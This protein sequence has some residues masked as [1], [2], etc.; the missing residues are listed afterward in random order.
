MEETCPIGHYLSLIVEE[1]ATAAVG[2]SRAVQHPSAFSGGKENL[3]ELCRQRS[4]G[5][6]RNP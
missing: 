6:E 1:N 3:E 5:S 4:N 2:F